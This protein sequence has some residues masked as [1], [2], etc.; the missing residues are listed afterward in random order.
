M[1]M[2]TFSGADVRR[3]DTRAPGE[4]ARLSSRP[5]R[6]LGFGHGVSTDGDNMRKP[7][8][9]GIVFTIIIHVHS[10]RWHRKH[11]STVRVGSPMYRVWP[12]QWPLD[13]SSLGSAESRGWHW[14][15]RSGIDCRD[16]RCRGGLST[17]LMDRSVKRFLIDES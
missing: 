16:R 17:H 4:S 8:D 7:R 9:R 1:I 6:G 3:R 5:T 15:R 12:L 10:D 2:L 14:K 13:T 11:T